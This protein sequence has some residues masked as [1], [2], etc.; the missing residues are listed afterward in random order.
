[1]LPRMI[2]AVENLA[3]SRVRP[4]GVENVERTTGRL[5]LRAGLAGS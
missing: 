3:I 2:A 1:M 5:R 4:L